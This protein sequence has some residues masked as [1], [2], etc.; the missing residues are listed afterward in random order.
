NKQSKMRRLRMGMIGGGIGSFMG[1][2][3]RKA[4]AMDGMIELVCGAFSS[5]A[6][7]S[8]ET[9]RSLYLPE[10]RCYGSFQE[11]IS[12]EK[13]LPEG[14]RMDFV[15]IVTPNHLHFEPAKMAL[16]NGFHVVCDKPM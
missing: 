14:E 5:T 2:V 12:N 9:G 8:R 1:G 11:M 15:A 10:E 16:E 3:H 7:K 13:E 6:E 4:S